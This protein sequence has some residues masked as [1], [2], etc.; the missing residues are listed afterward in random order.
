M[1]W[2]KDQKS[3]ITVVTA[4]APAVIKT[5][6]TSNAIDLQGYSAATVVLHVGTVTDG[7]HTPKLQE[8]DTTTSG[9]F[10]D[11]AAANLSGTFAALESD[12]MQRI[13]YI[14]RKRY[15]RVVIT[16]AGSPSTGGAY[17]AC[18]V[19]GRPQSLPQ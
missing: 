2:R 10:T 6:Q 7:T 3:E 17:S 12:T 4:V 19:R 14:G 15:V 8:S 11:V 1:S 5:T 13:G 18:V 16:V 9:D